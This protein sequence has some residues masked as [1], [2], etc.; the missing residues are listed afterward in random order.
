MNFIYEKYN[1]IGS[2]NK[3][4]ESFSRSIPES[5]ACRW[6][7]HDECEHVA[8]GLLGPDGVPSYLPVAPTVTKSLGP[9][10]IKNVEKHE[11]TQLFKRAHVRHEPGKSHLFSFLN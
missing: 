3:G 7:G 5:E 6:C 1:R 4:C 9:P 10:V 8:L 2:C 11:R